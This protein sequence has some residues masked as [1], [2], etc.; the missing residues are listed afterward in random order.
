MAEQPMQMMN[1]EFEEKFNNYFRRIKSETR[2]ILEKGWDARKCAS[3]A[4]WLLARFGMNKDPEFAEEAATY[5]LAATYQ[6]MEGE[7]KR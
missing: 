1:S 4:S 7:K 5:I 3:G 2:K 6:K